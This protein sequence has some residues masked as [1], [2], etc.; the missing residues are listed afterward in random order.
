MKWTNREEM[1][2]KEKYSSCAS[3][4]ELG[5]YLNRSIRS[6]KQKAARLGLSRGLA[7][8]NKPK[9]KR[10]RNISDKQYYEDNKK[11]IQHTKTKRLKR[12]KIEMIN[13]LGG[14]CSKCGYNHCWAA[15]EFHH[16]TS[17]KEG[18]MAHIIKN[19]SREKALKEGKKCIL[20]CANCHRELHN[21]GS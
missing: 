18:N 20:L 1:E 16:N 4:R 3:L 5:T 17:D 9:N 10:H 8:V 15:L 6:I 14:R 13:L 12:I 11:K 21:Q 2:L 7:P 19:K